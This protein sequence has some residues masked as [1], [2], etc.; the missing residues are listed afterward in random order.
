MPQLK[1]YQQFVNVILNEFYLK[2]TLF[3]AKHW[4]SNIRLMIFQVEISMFSV[5]NT[6]FTWL[7]T[8]LRSCLKQKR[9]KKKKKYREKRN[10]HTIQLIPQLGCQVT[11]PKLRYEN[12]IAW[13]WVYDLVK[14][15]SETYE[16]HMVSFSKSF[17]L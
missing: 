12:N 2:T 13:T 1:D 9:K 10:L 14:A 5:N 16:D 3:V 11:E 15:S 8:H 4:S 7:P 6:I 17:T